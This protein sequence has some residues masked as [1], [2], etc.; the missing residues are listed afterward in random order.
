MGKMQGAAGR[1]QQAIGN[2]QY[3]K[4]NRQYTKAKRK[5]IIS[6]LYINVV[7]SKSVSYM[8]K[9]VRCTRYLGAPAG[10]PIKI[11]YV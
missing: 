4:S 2:V 1:M 5:H 7:F 8:S 11:M 9:S 3:A 10:A 6:N